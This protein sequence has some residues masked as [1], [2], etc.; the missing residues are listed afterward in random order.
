M[1]Y[2]KIKKSR[3]L[4]ILLILIFLVFNFAGNRFRNFKTVFPTLT[5]FS[6]IQ[7]AKA[8]N[9]FKEKVYEAHEDGIIVFNAGEGQKVP[10]GYNVASIN[11]MV[12][13]SVLKDQLVKVNAALAYKKNKTVDFSANNER[14]ISI[15]KEIQRH[16]RDKNYKFLTSAVNELDFNT[17]QNFSITDLKELLGLE[18]NQLVEKRNYLIEQ[19]STN[20]IKY[21]AEFSGVVSYEMD[22]LEKYYTDDDFSKYKWDYLERYNVPTSYEQTTKIKKGSP[23]FKLIDNLDWNIAV[24]TKT[25]R[26]INELE[27]G[28]F[29]TLQRGDARFKAKLMQ[30]N[31][32]PQGSVLILKMYDNFENFY[33]SRIYD[34]QLIL[35]E[36][37]SYEIPASAILDRNGVKGVYVQEIHGLAK[38]IPVNILDKKGNLVSVSMG[39]KRAM[40]TI[41]DKEYKTITINDSV[42]VDYTK[43]PKG[44]VL[45]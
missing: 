25:S 33:Q 27:A 6:E 41:N 1:E 2:K 7:D 28:K 17:S 40:I 21:E 19:I 43:V 44:K 18:E 31:T 10:K 29:V 11:L 39:D 38:F 22:G 37:Q 15:I 34:L 12:D 8:Y 14:N 16:I 20:D 4:V 24:M 13:S 23:I 35:A 36:R 30:V 3:L 26:L 32:G 9:I 5:N 45:N 42:V